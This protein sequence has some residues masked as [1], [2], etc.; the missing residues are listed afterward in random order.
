MWPLLQ[1][2]RMTQQRGVLSTVLTGHNAQ[3][4]G[5]LCPI[6]LPPPPLAGMAQQRGALS[7]LPLLVKMPIGAVRS[8]PSCGRRH[9]SLPQT[10]L[11][12][13]RLTIVPPPARG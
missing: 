12:S 6:V 7:P 2:V 8:A 11:L 3:Q 9:H 4:R 5:T 10:L 13:E 1:P